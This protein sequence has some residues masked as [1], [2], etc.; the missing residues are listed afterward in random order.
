MCV[1]G[2]RSWAVKNN[3]AANGI[4]T[5][6]LLLCCSDDKEG[7][8]INRRNLRGQAGEDEEEGGLIAVD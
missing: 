1:D 7:E 8:S 3:V 4:R 6:C 2:P 5:R